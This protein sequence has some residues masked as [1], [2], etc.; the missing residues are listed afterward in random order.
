MFG[1]VEV[2]LPLLEQK[3]NVPPKTLVRLGLSY[4]TPLHS[5]PV[6]I[7]ALQFVAVCQ[8]LCNILNTF[9]CLFMAMLPFYYKIFENSLL[10]PI[11]K[12]IELIPFKTTNCF[13]S[14]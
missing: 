2:K 11:V 10:L 3:S 9:K 6:C 8:R 7:F 12:E 5:S 13:D 4:S 14:N 1:F